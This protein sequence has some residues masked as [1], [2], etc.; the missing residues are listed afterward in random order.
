MFRLACAA[1]RGDHLDCVEQ[2]VLDDAGNAFRSP[3]GA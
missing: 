3:F 2:I 1:L